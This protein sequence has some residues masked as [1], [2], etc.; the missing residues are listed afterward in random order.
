M[1]N[2]T[3][4]PVVDKNI[5]IIGLVL[6]IF[7]PGAGNIVCGI[8]T[9]PQHQDSITTGIITICLNIVIPIIAY[10]VISF[11]AVI[12]FG[13]GG[14]LY[15][16]VFICNI[17]AW[18]YGIYWSIKCVQASDGAIPQGSF[19]HPNMVNQQ[20]QQPQYQQTTYSGTIPQ[21][22][23][24]QQPIQQQGYQQQSYQQTDQYVQQ[25]P[26]ETTQGGYST[27]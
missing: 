15:P 27:L 4:V 24:Q 1:V 5:A 2:W 21:Q 25:N 17:A 10:I 12:T 13:I 6:N 16:F 19:V 7:F 26:S 14:L 11:V 23:Q 20:P 3:A 8:S 22:Q 9:N 18:I